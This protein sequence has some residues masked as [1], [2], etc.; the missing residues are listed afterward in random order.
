MWL[1]AKQSSKPIFSFALGQ[2]ESGFRGV[3]SSTLKYTKKNMEKGID[4]N[5]HLLMKNGKPF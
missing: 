3:I 1:C 2:I 5:K 4:E